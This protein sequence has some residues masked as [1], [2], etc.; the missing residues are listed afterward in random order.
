[1]KRLDFI[2]SLGIAVGSGMIPKS[3]PEK[4]TLPAK[5]TN[6]DMTFGING[7]ERM[8]ITSSGNHIFISSSANPGMFI[9]NPSTRLVFS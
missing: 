8:R 2:K 7:V 3:K 4:L 6:A 1:M 9:T 5:N